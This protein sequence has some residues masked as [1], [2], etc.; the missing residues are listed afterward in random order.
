MDVASPL[1]LNKSFVISSL[2]ALVHR[3][4]VTLRHGQK[5]HFIVLFFIAFV[6]LVLPFA[7]VADCAFA[8]CSLIFCRQL[9][10]TEPAGP[11]I[12]DRLAGNTKRSSGNGQGGKAIQFEVVT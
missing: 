9:G 7:G 8:V 2:R 11:R 10:V 6:A 3:I 5:P 4:R 12:V 1:F